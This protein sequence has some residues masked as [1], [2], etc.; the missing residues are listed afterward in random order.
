VWAGRLIDHARNL[1][2]FFPVD[3]LSG[4]WQLVVLVPLLASAVAAAA[5]HGRRA[6]LLALYVAGH[7]VLLTLFPVDQ[8][9]RYYLP[10]VAPL[11]VLIALGAAALWARRGR[12]EGLSMPR[13]M[14]AT[15]AGALIAGAT[16]WA[17]VVVRQDVT[18]IDGQT[19]PASASTRALA[20]FVETGIPI[21]SR[22]AFRKPRAL[23][24][25]TGRP[26][27]AI[28]LPERLD[29]IDVY[30]FDTEHL[31]FQVDQRALDEDVRFEVV[32]SG[33]PYRAY[34]RRSPR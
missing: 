23:R 17:V 8:G 5:I 22:I 31:S 19:G 30:L 2:D 14:W 4:R 27:V 18:T 3:V 6:L 28:A 24:Y 32:Y 33:P 10:L 26:A 29:R 21:E 16:A 15:C 25:L 7:L 34:R 20:R 12:I 9:T 13:R 1:A 11:A